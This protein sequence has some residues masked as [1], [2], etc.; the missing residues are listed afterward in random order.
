MSTTFRLVQC[1]VCSIHNA[2]LLDHTRRGTYLDDRTVDDDREPASGATNLGRSSAFQL[3][4]L[5][6]T[7]LRRPPQH[8]ISMRARESQ[9]AGTNLRK[10]VDDVDPVDNV[11]EQG[12]RQRSLDTLR[13]LDKSYGD[14]R[15]HFQQRAGGPN[16]RSTQTRGGDQS[17]DATRIP[18][19]GQS[20]GSELV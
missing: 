2:C 16:S 13:R 7:P 5:I 18:A 20:G 11:C 14:V 3:H 6:I 10:G 4:E 8:L 19:N 12:D 9:E 1:P 17:F 15:R